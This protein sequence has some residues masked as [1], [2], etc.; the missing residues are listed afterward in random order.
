MEKRL[1]S[2]ER[3]LYTLERLPVDRTPCDIWYTPEV[4]EALF[5]HFTT[6]DPFVVFDELGVDKILFLEAPWKKARKS[7]ERAA[8][9]TQWGSRIQYVGNSAG[10]Y[11]ET[12]HFPLAGVEDPRRALEHA[13]PDAEDFDYAAL[14]K[15]CREASRWV[16][17]LSFISL[18]EIYCKLKPMDEALMDLCINPELAHRII[19]RLLQFQKSY[20]LNAARACKDQLEIVYLSDD[21]GMQDRPLVSFTTWEEYF[22]APYR[23]LIDLS[24][25]LGMYTFYHSDGSAYEVLE[26]MAGMG[27]DI[28]N[29]IQYTC[30]GMQREKLKRN[31]GDKVIFHGGVENQRVIPFGTPGEVAQEVRDNIRILGKGGGYI[32]AP[33]HNIQPGTSVENVLALFRAVREG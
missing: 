26:A 11:E 3:I 31:L 22:K 1:T 25:S 14:R 19:D 21:M 20:I 18:F 13:W 17:M 2:R 12:V 24:H 7:E 28:V 4:M 23:E 5:S 27:V 6:R 9:T 16:R 15:S 32:C 10:G 8:T 33:C 30:P 29:P